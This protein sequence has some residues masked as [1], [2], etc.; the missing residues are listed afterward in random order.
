VPANAGPG[1]HS[2]FLGRLT[3]T[4]HLCF[5]SD[6]KLEHAVIR[7]PFAENAFQRRSR[8]GVF[9]W[10]RFAESFR[11]L[12]IGRANL[13]R[14]REG[15]L[16]A[17]CHRFRRAF[18]LD[19]HEINLRLIEK[20]MIVQ[21]GDFQ[22]ALEQRAHHRIHFVLEKHKVTHNHRLLLFAVHETLPRS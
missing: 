12:R 18:A 16:H 3:T 9:G 14:G 4:R 1:I 11:G 20:E 10:H 6:D 19:V 22:S 17:G 8:D 13:L 7:L 21:C 15:V 5:P 2:H